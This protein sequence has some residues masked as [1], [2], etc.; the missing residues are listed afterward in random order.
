[1]PPTDL[2]P[3]VARAREAFA[4][5]PE[6]QVVATVVR[7]DVVAVVLESE[8]G[9]YVS[10]VE[11]REGAWVAPEYLA[12]QSLSGA[13]RITR[14]EAHDPLP[15]LACTESMWPDAAGQ[16]PK[17][18]WFALTALAG[19]DAVRVETSSQLDE[20]HEPIRPDGLVLHILRVPTGTW[21][22][23]TVTTLDGRRLPCHRDKRSYD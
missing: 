6:V 13:A 2:H 3:A 1:M 19:L 20:C 11:H 16:Q 17:T 12:G 15:Q 5:R 21:P 23:I 9:R 22:E 10:L 18:A 4:S 8:E 7:H 14:T